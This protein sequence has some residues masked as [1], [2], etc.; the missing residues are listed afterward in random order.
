MPDYTTKT[1]NVFI[2]V[3]CR[4]KL[5]VEGFMKRHVKCCFRNP[6]RIEQTKRKSKTIEELKESV[7]QARSYLIEAINEKEHY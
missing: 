4:K 2:C 1:V 7:E 5:F 3:H 6:N